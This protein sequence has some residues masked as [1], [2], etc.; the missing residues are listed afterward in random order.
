LEYQK[1]MRELDHLTRLNIAY[2]FVQAEQTRRQSTTELEEMKAGIEELKTQMAQA[3]QAIE[4]VNAAIAALEKKRS[5]ESQGPIQELEKKV[6]ERAKACAVAEAT[7]KHSKDVLATEKKNHKALV[8]V[9]EEDK[10]LLD[11]KCSEVES[12]EGTYNDL[13]ERSRAAEKA[14]QTAQQHYQAVT[15][16]LCSSADGQDETLAA[17][18]IACENEISTAV[19]ETKQAEMRLKSAQAELKEKEGLCKDSEH[20]YS[21][22]KA[23]VDTIQKEI[24]KLEQSMKK[25]N[26]QDGLEEE[27]IAKRDQLMAQ[28]AELRNKVEMLESRFPLVQFEYQD[29]TPRFDRGKVKG[30][31]AKLVRVKDM[32]TATALE[33]SAGGKLYNIIVDTEETG[34][35]LLQRGQLKRRYTI[36]PLNKI[37]ARTISNDV[38]RKA[39]AL[40]GGDKVRPALTLVGYEEELRPAMSYVFGSMFVCDT[41]QNAKKVRDT[42]QLVNLLLSYPYSQPNQLLLSYSYSEPNWLLLSYS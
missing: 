42:H 37:T 19:T 31:V 7:L 28:V 33:V 17:Q 38:I 41:L 4:E 22:D 12:E 14:V 18:K 16:G 13:Q 29:P 5:E 36:I 10:A 35:Q 32:S 39:Q 27:L 34:K 30:P 1:V 6:D 20:A 25:L 21:R 2:Q 24:T 40:V 11:G 8:K 3:D 15:A 26:Y 9:C 23:S